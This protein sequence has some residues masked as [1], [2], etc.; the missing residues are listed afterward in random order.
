[1][2]LDEILDEIEIAGADPKGR[3]DELIRALFVEA[4]AARN[5]SQL[6]AKRDLGAYTAGLPC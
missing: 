2:R 1:M 6:K 5:V 3:D 4:R